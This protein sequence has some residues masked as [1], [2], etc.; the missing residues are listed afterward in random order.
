M[1]KGWFVLSEDVDNTFR[2]RMK[3]GLCG[4]RASPSVSCFEELLI[5]FKGN[6]IRFYRKRSAYT[7][8]ALNA[9]RYILSREMCGK[10]IYVH[11]QRLA[12]TE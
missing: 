9:K 11:L 2:L 3:N 8:I 4:G 6:V 7:I 1:G 5:Q 10:G 12:T